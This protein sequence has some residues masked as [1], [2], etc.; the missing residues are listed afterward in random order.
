[1]TAAQVVQNNLEVL[2]ETMDNL[3]MTVSPMFR[4]RFQ[5]AMYEKL[6]SVHTQHDTTQL[7]LSHA[8]SQEALDDLHNW[9]H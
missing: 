4:E 5:Q 7:D 2:F 1:M 9:I 8:L 6:E 3:L